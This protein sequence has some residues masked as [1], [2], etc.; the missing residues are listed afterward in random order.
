[1][2]LSADV[3][4][5]VSPLRGNLFSFKTAIERERQLALADRGRCML[6]GPEPSSVIELG[7]LM[8]EKFPLD[9]DPETPGVQASAESV[10]ERNEKWRD[11]LRRRFTHGVLAHEMGHRW[12]CATCSRRRSTPST[13]A[14]STR[15]LRTRDGAE[16]EY[17][18][19]AAEDGSECVGPRWL[20]PV[21]ESEQKGLLYRWQK[22]SV[23]DYPGDVTQETLDIGPY[24]RAALRFAYGDMVDMWDSEDA[25]CNATG[26]SCT[27]SGGLLV[28]QL[29]G[30]GGVTGPW[31]Q[32][33]TG[34]VHYSRLQNEL[35]LIRDCR[36]GEP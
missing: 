23:M 13:T 19:E 34:I 5:R 14:P 8:D 7:R 27:T 21:T 1:M 25:R 9:Q 12:G 2:P 3:L 33:S 30:F 35:G 4:D 31:Y 36:R 15:Q 11:Y 24:D 26:S 28:D 16:T 22:T 20:D 17:C 18:S 6:E 32:G 10:Y 29:D